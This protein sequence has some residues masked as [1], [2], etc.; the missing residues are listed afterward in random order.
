[1]PPDL[2]KENRLKKQVYMHKIHANYF[3]KTLKWRPERKFNWRRR[4]RLRLFDD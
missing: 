1:M 2:Q 3:L 4:E